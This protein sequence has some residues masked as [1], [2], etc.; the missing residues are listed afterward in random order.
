MYF[1]TDNLSVG[2][3]G[4]A[5]IKNINIGVEKGKILCLLGPNG[6]G[7][8]TIL[9]SISKHLKKIAGTVFI[10]K[11]DMN[12]LN[13]VEVAKRLSVVL[14]EKVAPELMTCEEVVAT[15]RYPY[16][17]HFGKLTDDDHRIIE[18]SM[19]AVSVLDL[20]DQE[21]THLSDGQK[22]RV[23]LARAICQQPEII[24]LDEPTSYLDIRHKIELLGILRS[25][26]VKQNVTVILSLHEVDLAAKL[27]DTIILVKDNTIFGS[28][29]PED[30]LNDG[31]IKT[32]YGIEAGSFN[33]LMGSVELPRTCMSD[34]R[35]FVFGGDGYGTRCY[36]ALHKSGISFCTGVLYHNDVDY[37]VAMSLAR[38]TIFEKS[39]RPISDVIY[40]QACKAMLKCEVIIDTGFDLDGETNRNRQLLELA[41]NTNKSILSLR[42]QTLKSKAEVQQF[43]TIGAMI[44]SEKLK[45]DSDE[46]SSISL[47][48]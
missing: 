22:Q 35:V 17:N 33:M 14:T 19:E 11:E 10:A 42:K 36:R 1:K 31:V 16:T 12:S 21:F 40:E 5:L 43:E 4:K 24:I 47:C 23:L 34:S 32:L 8:S 18:E 26:A 3:G 45:L 39:F 41:Y 28:G 13:S 37:Q 30:V 15:G 7:K 27:A 20:M 25:M 48:S 2:Y 46:M 38:Q 6:S 9:R 29:C 44:N